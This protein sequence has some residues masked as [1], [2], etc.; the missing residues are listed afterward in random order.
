MNTNT[1]EKNHAL[2]NARG[3]AQSIVAMVAALNCDY[4]RLEELRDMKADGDTIMDQDEADELRQLEADCRIDGEVMKDADEAREWIQNSILSVEVRSGWYEPTGNHLD[5]TTLRGIQDYA[6]HGRP[7]IA[8]HGRTRPAR[9]TV[10]R[11][12]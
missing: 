2:D 7:C 1:V 8:D 5:A 6:Y 10:A 9:R 11:M 3:W 12:D 4:D